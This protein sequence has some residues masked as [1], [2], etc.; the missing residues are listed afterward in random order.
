MIQDDNIINVLRCNYCD[1]VFCGTCGIDQ[2]KKGLT[3]TDA[4][5]QYS[6][7]KEALRKLKYIRDGA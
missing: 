6:A 7:Y 4:T 5:A 1:S 3:F 2:E